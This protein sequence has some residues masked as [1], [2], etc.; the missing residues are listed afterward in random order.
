MFVD[1]LGVTER[2]PW[3][4]QYFV[5]YHHWE[6]VGE[7]PQVERPWNFCYPGKVRLLK[8]VA[9]LLAASRSRYGLVR[10]S[11]SRLI[12]V[13]SS[14]SL[15]NAT[16]VIILYSHAETSMITLASP[17]R[18]SASNATATSNS[19]DGKRPP[20]ESQFVYKHGQRHHSYDPE[21]APYPVSYD[22][23]APS[24]SYRHRIN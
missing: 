5:G 3:L 2:W 24:F 1:S 13:F 19:F 9:P 23:W 8:L 6:L 4:L 14:F 18:P 11:E 15:D 20:K 17:P 22:R 7:T 10:R 21:K 16:R 12:P